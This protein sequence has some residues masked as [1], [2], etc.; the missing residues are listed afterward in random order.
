[1][2]NSESTLVTLDNRQMYHAK[3]IYDNKDLLMKTEIV[4]WNK[5]PYEHYKPRTKDIGV[6][7]ELYIVKND[8]ESKF[9]HKI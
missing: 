4:D 6:R 8:Y 9:A 5:E 1:M 7:D 2:L 3:S